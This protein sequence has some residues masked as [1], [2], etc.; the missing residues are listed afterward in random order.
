MGDGPWL[1]MML[2]ER[3]SGASRVATD[4]GQL[5]EVRTRVGGWWGLVGGSSSI[6]SARSP[7]ASPASLTPTDRTISPPPPPRPAPPRTAPH[8]T[9]SDDHFSIPS[10]TAASNT[11][12][13]RELVLIR[14]IGSWACRPVDSS[15][16]EA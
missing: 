8:R 6:D 7:A 2:A 15:A 5:S 9:L 14:F 12:A 4:D 10:P 13:A 1:L 11:V 3:W 16:R